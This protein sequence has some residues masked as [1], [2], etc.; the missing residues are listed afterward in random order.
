MLAVTGAT[1]FVGRGMRA[2][3]EASGVAFRAIG[4]EDAPGQV[5]VGDIG[6]ETEWRG[7]LSGV[8]VVIHLAARV[9]HLHERDRDPLGVY[10]RTN[11]AGTLRLAREAQA[12][13][14]R[15]LVFVSSVKVNGERTE[16]GRPFQSGDPARPLDPY[17]L[18]KW[19]AEQELWALARRTGLEVAVVRPP[20]VYGA[21]VGANFGALVALV[22]RGVPLPLGAIRN[23]RSLI[24]VENLTDLLLRC[25]THPNAP[26]GTFLCSD[27]QDV[28]TPELVRTIGRG[29]KRPVRLV[30]VPAWGLGLAAGLAGRGA[31]VQ[32]LT[33]SLQVD[34]SETCARLDWHPPYQAEDAMMRAAA[35]WTAGIA[36]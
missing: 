34:A 17:G 31:T 21:E 14:V 32:R 23:K 30:P 24:A 4:R 11:V 1:G 22:Q 36:R 35:G 8:S 12:G 19:E 2:T 9:H 13:G 29:L 28:S 16:P 6:P 3:L 26:G 15:R 27:G 10:R 33:E 20:L 25:A 5:G 18:S 7:A